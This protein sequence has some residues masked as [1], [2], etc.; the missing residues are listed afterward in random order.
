MGSAKVS[1]NDEFELIN[2]RSS[3]SP[4]IPF[5]SQTSRDGHAF[6][7]KIPVI[8]LEVTRRQAEGFVLDA[9]QVYGKWQQ[10]Q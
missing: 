8:E 10:N 5:Y 2:N 6:L 9:L 1:L 3:N 4:K 7:F